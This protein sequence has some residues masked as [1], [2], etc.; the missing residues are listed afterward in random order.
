MRGNT[1]SYLVQVRAASADRLTAVGRL[2]VHSPEMVPEARLRAL[3]AEYRDMFP[4]DLPKGLPPPERNVAHLIPL[5]PRARP[6]YRPMYRLI[7]VE[8]AEVERRIADLLKK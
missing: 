4:A 7:V 5:E 8:K 6:I 2:S 3:L 1:R